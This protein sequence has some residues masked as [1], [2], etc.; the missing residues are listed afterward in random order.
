M[1]HI[2]EYTIFEG[3]Y[4]TDDDLK[5]MKDNL[6]KFAKFIRKIIINFDY[7]CVDFSEG[8]DIQF[9]FYLKNT[10]KVLFS[11]M[12]GNDEYFVLDS[13]NNS[14]NYIISSIPEYMKTIKGIRFNKKIGNEYE[15]YIDGN[16]NDIINQINNEKIK[17]FAIT[18]K[19]NI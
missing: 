5:R 7:E 17:L 16:V 4:Y 11:I 12:T 14:N 2:K 15:F 10:E 18:N 13:F 1:K 8:E 6:P 19:F 9:S 3:E